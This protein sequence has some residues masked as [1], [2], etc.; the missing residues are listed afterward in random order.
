MAII[1]NKEEKRRVIALS[2]SE[3]L[4]THG[5]DN[6]TISEIAKTAGVGKGTIYE[7]FENKEDIVFE[8]I[9]T[10]MAGY[11][12]KLL[13]VVEKSA[14]VKK[15][16]YHFFALIFE[17]P[18]YHKQLNLYQEFLA[19]SLTNGTEEMIAFSIVCKKRFTDI[20]TQIIEEAIKKG[21][22]RPEARDLVPALIIFEKGLVVDTRATAIDAEAEITHFLDAL[23]EL[24]M[25]KEGR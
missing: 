25:V 15:R 9:T 7:Y 13:E 14:S 8:I 12:E 5:I 24:I 23:F 2:C 16:I 20:L 6:L 21:E 19:I 10:F 3:L 11:E 22:I 4:L 17:D 18:N 1:V